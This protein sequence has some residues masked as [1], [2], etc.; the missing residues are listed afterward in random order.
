[1]GLSSNSIIHITAYREALEGIIKDNFDVRCCRENVLLNDKS[2]PC[3]VPMVS[4]CDI[5]LSQVKNHLESYGDKDKKAYGIGLT[6]EWAVKMKLNPVLYVE[7]ES[8]LANSYCYSIFKSLNGS[9][10][11]EFTNSQKSILDILRYMKNYQGDLVRK[12]KKTIDNYRFSDERE[13]RYVPLV[14]EAIPNCF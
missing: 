5:P 6:K 8:A 3:L 1:M 4:F 12:G 13:W 14:T 2:F 7:K 9:K 11:S 10:L